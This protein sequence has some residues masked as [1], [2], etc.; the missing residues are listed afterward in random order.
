MQEAPAAFNLADFESAETATLE[1]LG[2]TGEPLMFNG[3]SVRIELYGPG[4]QQGVEAQAKMEQAAQSIAMQAAVAAGKGKPAKD[5]ADEMRELQ[6]KK[7][8]AVT[9]TLINFPVPGGPLALYS[10]TKLG[11]ITRQVERFQADWANF[12]VGS[13]RN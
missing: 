9:K 10:N 1:V 12:P 5:T 13:S 4:S 11:Y 8:A 6:L 3:H 7:L 2:P